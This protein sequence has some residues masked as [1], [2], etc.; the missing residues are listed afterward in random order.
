MVSSRGT[1]HIFLLS[2]FGGET[3]IQLLN[4]KINGQEL[5]AVVS[6]PWWSTSSFIKDQ[7]P[8]SPPAPITLSVVSRIKNVSFG[9]IS[10]ATSG[11]TSVPAG[12]ITATFHSSVVS[13]AEALEHLLVYAPSGYVIQYELSPSLGREQ[14]ERVGPASQDEDL[15]VKVE[16]V[17]WWDVCRRADWPEKEEFI[18]S[19]ESVMT[20]SD[21]EDNTNNLEKD[22][23]KQE[24]SRWFLSKAEVQIRSGRVP[25]WQKS[26][27][28]VTNM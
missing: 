11:K 18:G 14:G 22:L 10:N 20:N 9:W 4:S 25:V 6:V 26:K 8:S 23:I 21:Y 16:P 3:G 15:R 7:L 12:V 19:V 5:S 24:Q 27:V 17:Q 13:N 2:P 28:M 1:C